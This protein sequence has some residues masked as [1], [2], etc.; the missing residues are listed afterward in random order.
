MDPSIKA[1]LDKLESTLEANTTAQRATAAKID[2][3]VAWKPDLERRVADLGDAVAAFQLARPQP[4]KDGEGGT[5]GTTPTPPPAMHGD[6]LGVVAGA[7][8][9]P[10]GSSDHGGAHL[11]RELPAASFLTPPPLPANSQIALQTPPS[12][13]SPFAHA[14]QMLAGLGQAH[15]SIVFPSSPTRTHAYGKRCVN[16]TFKRLLYTIHFGFPWLA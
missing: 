10:P 7:T 4:S 12:D 5:V 11:Q 13:V 9:A 14:S 2:E 8:H 6:P 15:P 16:N 1:F 3:I